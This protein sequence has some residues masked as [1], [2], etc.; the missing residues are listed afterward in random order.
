MKRSLHFYLVVGAFG[1][2]VSSLA[3]TSSPSSGVDLKAIDKSAD[4]CQDFYKYACGNWM[5]A[6]PIPPQYSRWGRF[7]E[8]ADRNQQ[9]LHKILD[10]S[11]KHQDRSPLDQKIG[12]FYASC[13]DE[14]AVD[15]AGDTPIKPGIDRIQAIKA[16]AELAS[17]VARLHDQAVPVFFSFRAEADP[18]KASLNIADVDQGG[19]G[20]PDRSYYL[21]AK[22]EKTRQKY[23]EHVSRMFQLI[24]DSAS[25]ADAKAKAI[26]TLETALAKASL[27]RVARRDPHLTHHKMTDGDLQA[28][29]P[30]FN[31]KNYFNGRSAPEFDTLNV[32]VPDY[33][34]ALN[35]TLTSTSLD[36]LKSYMIWH[37]VSSY[38]PVLSKPFVDANFDFYS[39]YLTGAQELLPRWK[40]CVQLTDRSLG[41]ALG[42][43]YV[44]TA[45]AGQSKEKTQ[46]LVAT[47]EKEMETDINSLTWMSDDTKR[48]ALAK[49]KGVSNKIGYPEKWRDYSSVKISDGDLVGDLR[50]GREFEI[51]RNIAKIGK[52]VDRTEFGM[53]P[54]TVNAYYNPSENNINFPAGI[55]QPPFYTNTADMAVN[56]G[57]VGAVIGHE[58]TH[59]FDDQGRQYDA[60]G[61]LRDWWTQQDAAEF[62]TRAD[63]LVN[64]YSKFSP[65]EGANVNGRLTL[66]ENGADNAGIRLAFMALMGGLENGT[67]DKDKIDGYTP[68]QRFFLGYA[69][70]WCAN[71]RPE[72]LRNSVRTNPHSPGEFRVIGV[73]ENLPEFA[74]AFGCSAG[75]PMAVANGCRVW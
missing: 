69:Q 39:R 34:K 47:I 30:D 13:M 6:N 51:H 1:I 26:L 40:R 2:C 3:Q 59:G 25:D 27:D 75:Q 7:D 55:L 71:E 48:Q 23:V 68:Q 9:V 50:N 18:D 67:V 43:K 17:E 66:G 65:V 15:K 14:A 35:Q 57:G 63:C 42:Q 21:E 8:L 49:L 31:F 32:S 41:E 70:I 45:F 37:Y 58:L 64:E 5:K 72:A 33:F 54:P 11:A 56:F 53:T 10:D 24:G 62:K 61:N 52:P 19:L 16:K 20:L 74:T 46:E 36:D 73:V 4:P 12:A 28:L 44:E 29:T 38:A 22:D 60:D